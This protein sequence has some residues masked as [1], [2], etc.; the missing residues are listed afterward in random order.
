MLG[1]LGLTSDVHRFEFDKDVVFSSFIF[2]IVIQLLKDAELTSSENG[3]DLTRQ[4]Q[5]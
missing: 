5:F 2:A 3:K 4:K 1:F